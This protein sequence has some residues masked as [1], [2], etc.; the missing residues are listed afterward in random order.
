MDNKKNTNSSFAY[1]WQLAWK[2]L[3]HNSTSTR[4]IILVVAAICLPLLIVSSIKEGYVNIIKDKI[5]GTTQALRI[6]VSVSSASDVK[7]YFTAERLDSLRKN[8]QV[9]EIVPQRT[10]RTVYVL[11]KDNQES[12]YEMKTSIPT[13]PDLEKFG[14]EGVFD[15]SAVTRELSVIVHEDDLKNIAF[16]SVN[17]IL[18]VI[19]KRDYTGYVLP[20]K[21]IGTLTSGPTGTLYIPLPMDDKLERWTLGFAVTFGNVEPQVN[22]PSSEDQKEALGEPKA[23]SAF[24]ISPFLFENPQKLA[25][26]AINF[27]AEEKTSEINALAMYKVTAANP[28]IPMSLSVSNTVQDALSGDYSVQVIPYIKPI[29]V[30]LNG[31]RITLLPSITADEREQYILQ[32]GKWLNTFRNPFEIMVPNSMSD[33]IGSEIFT[34]IGKDS[35]RFVP[36]GS[37]ENEGMGYI[38]YETLYRLHQLAAGEADL[39][40][41]FG[42]FQPNEKTPYEDRYLFARVHAKSLDGIIP[43]TDYFQESGYEI[44]GS[45]RGQVEDLKTINSILTNF[46]LLINI[47]GLLACIAALFVLMYEAIKRKRNQIGIM[48][49]MGLSEGFITNTLLMQSVFYGLIG[50]LLSF[51][52][53]FLVRFILDT[54]VGKQVLEIQGLEGSIFQLSPLLIL[55]FFLGVI[56]IGYI[57]GFI[58]ARSI[59]NINPA[60]ILADK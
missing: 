42:T 1:M 34:I 59:K 12:Q 23:D 44:Y 47:T 57:S 55:G 16:D 7:N 29:E 10:S 28:D 27:V 43:V 33:Q 35:V 36:S 25:L 41:H 6:D 40:L 54:S 60:D 3:Q 24:A 15:E 19:M 48:R 26:D 11:D 58:V 39:N 32:E 4:L 14:F 52:F 49:A 13:D 18:N 51:L 37:I 9:E 30:N 46:M 38:D 5:I 21:I 8:P 45:S 22:L 31:E 20:C 56:L 2:E 17:Q 50:L 53:F